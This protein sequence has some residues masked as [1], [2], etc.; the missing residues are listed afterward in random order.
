MI[1]IKASIANY[2]AER[3]QRFLDEGLK[4]IDVNH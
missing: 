3:K 1:E 4:C 2:V